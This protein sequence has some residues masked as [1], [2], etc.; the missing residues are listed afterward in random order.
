[1]AH[2]AFIATLIENP[3]SGEKQV[4]KYLRIWVMFEMLL[5]TRSLKKQNN[6]N[7]ILSVFATVSIDIFHKSET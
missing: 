5:K 4:E 1:M 7:D 6:L 3:A 2:S